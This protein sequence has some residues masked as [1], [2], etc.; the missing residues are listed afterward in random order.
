MA[1]LVA[2][3]NAARPVT[4]GGI[5]AATAI[6]GNDNLNVAGASIAS[7][8]TVN[9]AN[10]TGVALTITGTVGIS[11]FGT[12]AAGAERVLTFAASLTITYNATAMILPGA[13]NIVTAA[14][15]VMTVRSLGGG[16]WQ[17]VSYQRASVVPYS[18]SSTETLSNKSLVDATTAIVD[19]GD[20]T[21]KLKFQ[22]S[23]ITTATT[24]TVTVPDADGTML[25]SSKQILVAAFRNLKIIA[26]S[27]TQATVTADALTVEDS[28]GNS[29][30]LTTVNVT[31][32]IS[33]AGANGLDTGAEAS[34]TWYNLW[35]IWNG[36]TTSALLSLSATA[37][38]MPGG[39]T[40]KARVGVVRNDASANLWRTLQYGR[41]VH[42][43][44]GVNPATVPAIA[45]GT[46]GSPTTPTWTA[47]AVG[48]FV[49]ATAA[50]IRGTMI[51]AQSDNTRAM[52][53]PN[54][55]YGA[56]SSA[57]GAPVGN[58]NT[59]I[60]GSTIFVNLQFDL[61]L[62]STNIYYASSH[63]ST[64]VLLNGWEDN[65]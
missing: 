48:S 18:S 29:V 52:L 20:N 35:V 6:G 54:N 64:S 24:R 61:I 13:A 21:K 59:G 33:A 15:D 3:A 62:E 32:D 51:M 28:G 9:L 5:G 26:T 44:N 63:G 23:G 4:A 2:D 65:I 17:C 56:W 14:G 47:V 49:P 58:G 42:V 37:P 34:S 38:T 57:N 8:A 60:T 46:S 10:A 31:A 19:D 45:S 30:R 16:N 53:A 50:S 12:V 40:H 43:Q 39:Y 25:L 41:R 22:V 36:T 55:S 27:N 11:S 7:A 1:D